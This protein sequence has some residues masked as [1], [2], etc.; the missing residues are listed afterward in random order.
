MYGTVDIQMTK[1][2]IHVCPQLLVWF[3]MY[4]TVDIQM[5]NEKQAVVA[6]ANFMTYVHPLCITDNI[7]D[8]VEWQKTKRLQSLHP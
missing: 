4:G 3:S 8:N 1:F 5:I 2:C 7:F 6:T